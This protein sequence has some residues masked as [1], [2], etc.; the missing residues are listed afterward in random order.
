MCIDEL[1]HE[2]CSMLYMSRDREST[3]AKLQICANYSKTPTRG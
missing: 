3:I 2:D 1:E